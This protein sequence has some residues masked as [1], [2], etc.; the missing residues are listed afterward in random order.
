[1][2]YYYDG[3]S[4]G[5]AS[6]GNLTKEADWITGSTYATTLNT[7]NSYGLVTQTLDPRN[8]TT[9]YAYDT[10]NLYP[11]TTTNALSQTTGYQYDY[12]SGK[13]TQT[14]DPNSDV[15]QTAY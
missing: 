15:F 13:P 11:A 10:N 4:L 14:T 2:Q 9:T 5:N 3:L 6:T 7:F 8:S 12:S 1:T